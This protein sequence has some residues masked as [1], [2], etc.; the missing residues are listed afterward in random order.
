MLLSRCFTI[1]ARVLFLIPARCWSFSLHSDVT[2]SLL[3]NHSVGINFNTCVVVGIGVSGAVWDGLYAECAWEH[4]YIPVTLR[5]G[6]LASDGCTNVLCSD[7]RVY[8]CISSLRVVTSAIVGISTV[9]NNGRLPQNCI[10]AGCV[11]V[12]FADAIL[13]NDD[14]YTRRRDLT[15]EFSLFSFHFSVRLWCGYYF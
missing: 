3:N 9:L 15:F 7:V 13:R 4:K 8:H 14:I 12:R 2:I 11:S 1:A 10:L 5:R 6:I